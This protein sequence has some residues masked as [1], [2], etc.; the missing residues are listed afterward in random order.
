[1]EVKH[2]ERGEDRLFKSAVVLL[3]YFLNKCSV[4]QP[5]GAI[6]QGF[7]LIQAQIYLL[8]ALRKVLHQRSLERPILSTFIYVKK[9]YL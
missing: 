5:E 6:S 3:S 4:P 9:F 2:V 8:E 1:M 7:V